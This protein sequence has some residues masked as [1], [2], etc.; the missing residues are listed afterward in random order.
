[1]P[2][3]EER[4]QDDQRLKSS[5]RLEGAVPSL[6]VHRVLFDDHTVQS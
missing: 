5:I 2:F 4:A 6:L 1:V 3:E